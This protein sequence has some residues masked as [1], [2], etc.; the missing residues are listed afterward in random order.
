M[1]WQSGLN[2]TRSPN[3]DPFVFLAFF[4]VCSAS[5]WPIP[6][7]LPS[8]EGASFLVHPCASHHFNIGE[9]LLVSVRL[10]GVDAVGSL[11]LS[12]AE[13][14]HLFTPVLKARNPQPHSFSPR[15]LVRCGV[16][17][18]NFWLMYAL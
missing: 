5:F 16:Y 15:P 18:M 11:L 9:Q 17:L 2:S 10:C 7:L 12:G 3:R 4:L 14:G 8:L 6:P 1:N 13:G